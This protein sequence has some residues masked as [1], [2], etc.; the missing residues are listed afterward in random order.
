M[1]RTLCSQAESIST[2]LCFPDGPLGMGSHKIWG[3][4]PPFNVGTLLYQ[5][6]MHI[7]LVVLPF[8]RSRS[9]QRVDYHALQRSWNRKSITAKVNDSI[10]STLGLRLM[11]ANA[12]VVSSWMRKHSAPGETL[13]Y[14]S[15]SHQLYLKI[16]LSS[17]RR[18][19]DQFQATICRWR[20]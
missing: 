7:S 2:L 20:L 17:D 10:L 12:M 14:K 19:S 3:A 9:S 6:C 15:Q 1:G 13:L 4:S 16:F 18:V 11:R 5:P 8:A